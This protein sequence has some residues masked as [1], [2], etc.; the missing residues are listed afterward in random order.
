VTTLAGLFGVAGFD[1][2]VG[3]NAR[4]NRPTG[5]TQDASGNLYVT[6]TGNSTIRKITPDGT[7]STLVGLPTIA[8]LMD[9]RGTDALL[10]QPEAICLVTYFP[11]PRLII[12][13]TGNAAI[14]SASLDGNVFT[15]EMSLSGS[16]NPVT[17]PPP[18]PIT[19][20]PPPLPASN[21]ASSSGGGAL[22]GWL[23]GLLGLM[24][25]VRWTTSRYLRLRPAES[26]VGI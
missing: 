18:T 11:Q 21:S 5:M 4:F 17:V 25:L 22:D 16:V 7:V 20:L 8:G 26:R 14:R 9:G 15:L 10:N 1:D 13:D 24:F 3:I 6:D 12:A 19:P 2:G 23:A